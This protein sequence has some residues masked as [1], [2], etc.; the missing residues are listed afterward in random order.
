MTKARAKMRKHQRAGQSSRAGKE[1]IQVRMGFEVQPISNSFL[2]WWSTA[3]F[4]CVPIAKKAGIKERAC[5]QTK[6]QSTH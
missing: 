1:S 5:G 3:M 2:K 4:F 6:R